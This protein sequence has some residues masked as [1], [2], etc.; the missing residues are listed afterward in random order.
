MAQTRTRFAN[1][2]LEQALAEEGDS[3]LPA[4]PLEGD[5]SCDVA[6]VGGGYTGLWTA[7]ELKARDPVLDVRLIEKHICGWGASSRNAGYLLNMWA[8]YPTMRRLF[9]TERALAVGRAADAALEEVVSFCARNGIDAE[10]A[11]RG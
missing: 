9:G 6:I 7:I 5:A 10:I 8:K 4:P 1:Y 2:W 11:R 3:T